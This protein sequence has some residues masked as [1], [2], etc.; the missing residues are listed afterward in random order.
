[1]C[2]VEADFK[3]RTTVA[4]EPGTSL[5]NDSPRGTAGHAPRPEDDDALKTWFGQMTAAS[6]S[7]FGLFYA[8]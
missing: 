4:T 7:I 6:D 8:L 3:E 5:P 2:L 1:M